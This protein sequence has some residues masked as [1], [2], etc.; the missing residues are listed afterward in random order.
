MVFGKKRSR[1]I[2]T[3]LII[4]DERAME[5]GE[6]KLCKSVLTKSSLLSL[7]PFGKAVLQ[8]KIKM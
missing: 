5:L 2:Q 8:E 4:L 3:Q 7:V 6:V 1:F